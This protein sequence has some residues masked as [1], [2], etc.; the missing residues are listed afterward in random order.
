MLISN[1]AV[2]LFQGD[3]I[4]DSGRDRANDDHLGFGYAMMAASWFMAQHPD[5]DVHFLNRGVGGDRTIDLKARWDRD[6]IALEPTLVSIL[7]GINDTWRRYDQNDPTSAEGFEA[8]YRELLERVRDETNAQIVLLEPFL[9]HISEERR[10]WRED[11]DPKIEAV[12]RLAGEFGTS[13]VRLDDVFREVARF[14]PPHFWAS[15][16]VHP[17]PA[18]HAV[19]AREWL[20]AAGARS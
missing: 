5:H 16:G 20:K 8:S 3:S 1:G 7:A 10:S 12:R 17:T 11:L 13:L 14:K 15:D 19:I 2:V 9:L 6:C 18:G 4:T